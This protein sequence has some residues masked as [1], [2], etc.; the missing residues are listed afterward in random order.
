MLLQRL[1]APL[2]ACFIAGVFISSALKPT[3]AYEKLQANETFVMPIDGEGYFKPRDITEAPKDKYGDE[4]RL[5]YNIFTQTQEYAP[6]YAGRAMKCSNCHLHAGTKANAS[7][8]WAAYSVYPQYFKRA[9]KVYSLTD[10]IRGCFIYSMNG[11]APA[12]D[13]PEMRALV[14]YF[15]FLSEGAPAATTLPGRSFPLLDYTG[16]DPSKERGRKLYAEKCALCHGEQGQGMKIENT[17][18]YAY[19]PLW[20][21][22]SY[23]KGASFYN[24]HER[25]AR[26]IWA[27]MPFGQD[28]SLSHQ[29]ARDLAYFINMHDRPKNPRKSVWSDLT[30]H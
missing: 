4:V 5:G 23:N 22:D 7:P 30:G 28:Y 10:R 19:P 16:V 20:G 6:R 3:Q 18:T 8:M 13:A 14:S 25:L 29:D 24:D 17:S 26:F 9:D 2:F 27:N 15:H 12:H 11:F 1:K 21:M